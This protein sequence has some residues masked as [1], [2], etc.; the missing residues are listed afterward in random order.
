MCGVNGPELEGAENHHLPPVP[1]QRELKFID[2]AAK[3]ILPV[4]PTPSLEEIAAQPDVAEQGAPGPAPQQPPRPLRVIVIGND[5]ALSAV[6]TRL[7]RAD[8]MWVELAYVPTDPA[9]PAAQV[10]GLPDTPSQCLVQAVKGDAK[11]MPLIRDDAGIALMGAATITQAGA[12]QLTGEIVI[13]N[14]VLISHHA[15]TGLFGRA[16]KTGP[17]GARIVPTTDAPGLAGVALHNED[18]TADASSVLT[19]R[20]AQAGGP[21]LTV[22]VDGIQRPRSVEKVTFYRHLRDAQ[23]VRPD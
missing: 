19:G 10:L 9:S 15:Q 20:A 8:I 7:M 1:S 17:K 14:D 5:S 12:G 21:A 11:P 22:T 4:D 18:L 23:V 6:A 16:K 13:D 3:D 2:A